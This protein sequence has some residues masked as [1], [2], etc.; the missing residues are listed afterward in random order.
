MLT[1]TVRI[2]VDSYIPHACVHS[3]TP[4][5]YV[6]GR[7][8]TY[9]HTLTRHAHT[10]TQYRVHVCVHLYT[11]PRTCMCP[12]APHAHWTHTQG[13]GQGQTPAEKQ[14]SRD[15]QRHP[16]AMTR[17]DQHRSQ[18]PGTHSACSDRPGLDVPV[19]WSGSVVHSSS[20]LMG[21]SR[22]GCSSQIPTPGDPTAPS[23]Q[24]SEW[25]L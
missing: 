4:Q 22:A 16:V 23:S 11:A 10:C 25:K 14:E 12:L 1:H 7:T 8:P 20:Q 18:R 17:C 24:K 21:E 2:H 3:Y 15:G 19:T 9:T 5:A 13:R 6:R